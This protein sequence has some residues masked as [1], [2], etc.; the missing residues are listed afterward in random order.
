[1][2]VIEAKLNKPLEADRSTDSHMKAHQAVVEEVQRLQE[3]IDKLQTS[4]S[5]QLGSAAV[6]GT[7]DQLAMQSTLTVLS[8]RMATIQMKASG[9]RQLL[10]ERVSDRL[11][12]QHQEQ[13]LQHYLNQADQMDQWLLSTRE[14]LTSFLL[15]SAEEDTIFELAFLLLLLQ[16]MLHEIEQKVVALSELT[17]R[18][19]SLLLEGRQETRMDMR[20]D[21]EQLARKLRT[22]KGSLL[23]LQRMLQDKHI[24][25][26]VSE[27][28][29]TL[30]QGPSVQD[31]LVQAHT[32]HSQHHQ[33]SLQRQRL[34]EQLAEQKKLLQSVASRGEEILI[35]QASPSS[36]SMTEPFSPEILL[37]REIRAAQYQMRQRWESLRKELSTKL[38]LLQK[39]LEQDHKQQVYSRTAAGTLFKGEMGKTEDK[40]SLKMLYEVFSQTMK[41]MSCQTGASEGKVILME[42]HLYQAVSATSSWLDGVENTLFSGPVLL[43]ENAETQLQNQEALGKDVSEVTGEVSHSR[44][45]LGQ[46][47]GLC[48]E[49][50]VLLEDTLDCLTERLQT[51]DSALE[52]RCEH[53]RTRMQELTAYQVSEAEEGLRKFEQRITQL[54]TR[55]TELQ[56][57]QMSTNEMLKLQD[58]YEELMMTVGS[59]RSGL[60]QNM[61]LK[62]QYE[63]ALQDLADMVGTA[64]DKMAGDQRV[65]ASSVEEVQ[66][67]I[68]KH[69]EFFQGLESHM[70]LTET[71]FRKISG[72]VVPR[73]K[74]A[75]EERLTQAQGVLKQAHRRGVELEYIL[76][77]WSRLVPDYQALCMQLEAVEGSIPTVGLVEETEESL[78]ERSSLYQSLKGRLTEHQHKLSQVLE[79]GKRL[80]L[81]VCC[82][83]L[84]TQLTMLGEH[85]PRC[86]VHWMYQKES[87]ELIGWL[88]SAAVVPQEMEARRDH[89]SA[90]LD[91][92]KEVESHSSLKNSVLTEG[93]QLLRLKRVGTTALR[94]DLAHIDLEWTQLLTLIP[95]VQEK[96]HQLQMEKL[97]S[98]HAISELVNWMSL[99][100]NVIGEDEENLKG[101]VGSTVIQDYLQ[102]YKGFRVDVRCKQLTVDFVN[103]SVL[104]ISDQDVE[105]KRSDQTDFAEKLGVMNR[106]WQLLQGLITE[107]VQFLET[108]LEAWLNYE[109]N[110]QGLKTWL[111]A[112]EERLKR[113]PRIEDLTSVQN[114][115]NDC[116][117]MEEKVKE[118]EG[119][120]ERVEEQACALIQNKTDEACAV[121]METLQAVNHTW[122]NLDHLIGQLKI[123]LV[124]VLDQWNLYKLSSEE[125]NGYLMEGRYSVSRFRLLTG[126]LEAVQLQVESHQSLQEEL[127]K[128]EGSLRKFGSVTHQLLKECHP[129]VSDSLNNTLKD[130]NARWSSLLEEI[131][132]C[133]R[134]SKALL[135]L[136]QH[137]KE[138]YGKSSSSVQLQE[139][140]A[141]RLL[142]TA[143]TK[144]ITDEEVSTW[145]QDCSELLRAQAPVKASLQVIQELG[146][147]LKQQVETSA[148]S[149]VQSDHLSLTQRL[150]TVEQALSRQLT[151]L[152][153]GVQDYETFSEQLGALG[154]WMVEAEEALKVQDPNGSSDLSI[155]QDRMEELKRQILRFSSMAHD[156]EHLNELGYRLPLNDIEIK[157][158]QNLNRSWSAANTQTTER[159]SK[160]QSFLLQQQTFLEK[161]ETWMEFLVQTEEKLAVEI[162]GNY[163][164]LMEQQR[165]HKLFQAEMFSRQQILH[166]IISDGQRMLAQGQVDDRD[167]FNLK[168]SLLSNQWQGVVRRA[169]QRQ[170]II[171][172]LIRQWQRYRDMSEKLRKWLVEVSHPAEALLAGAPVPL[173]QT[174][175]MLD[176]VQIKEKVLQRQQ[177]SYILTV[178]A[179]KQ[180][181]LSAD[182]RAEVSLQGELTDIQDRWRCATICLEEQRRELD[183]LM[184]DWE[185]C[186][187]G[188]EGS[189]EKLREFKRQ[190]SQPLPDHH[191]DLQAEQMRCKDLEKTFDGWTEDLA[192]LTVL[193]E[194]LSS[195]ISAEDL[196]VLQERMELL[197]RQWE[198]ICHQLS[199]RQQQVGEKL[200]EWVVFKEKNRELCD[201]LTQMESKVSQNR[202][203]RIEEMI[204]KLRKDYYEEIAVA[205]EN[206]QQLHQ[207]GER[208]ARASHE[209]KASEIEHKLS[210]VGERWQHLLDLI[211]ARL[212]KLR[213]TLVAVQQLDKNMI[214][215]RSWLTHIETELSR[216]ILYDNCDSQEIQRKLDLQQ[217]NTVS[218]AWWYVYAASPTPIVIVSATVIQLIEETWRLWQKFLEDFM[219]FE[220]WLVTSEKTAALPN[221]SGVLYTVAKEELKKFEAFQR[222][223]HESLTQLETINKQYR[224]LAREN[225]TDSSCR[226]REMS[227]DGNQRWDNLQKRV[228][229]ILRRLKHFISQREEFETA[230]ESVVVWLTEMDL[231][232]TNIEHFSECDIQAKIKQLRA[233]QQ[234]IS[235]TTGK[236]EHIIHQGEVLLEKSEPLDAAVIEEELEE[237][238]RYYQEV[239]GRVE[240]YYKKLIR[241]PVKYD[242]SFSDREIELD[243]PGDLSSIPLSEQLGDCLS[244]PLPSLTAPLRTGAERSGRGSPATVDS[245]P[246]EWD[247]DYDLRKRL[248]SASRDLGLASDHG[249]HGEEGS[250]QGSASASR[251]RPLNRE[252]YAFKP[253]SNRIP[254]FQSSGEGGTLDTHILQLDR[255][256]DTS[257]LHL[258]QTE[259]IIRSRTPTG[260][261]LDASYMGYMRLLGECRSSIDTVKR[262]GYEL[263][264]EGDKALGLADPN[265]DESQTTGVIQRWE[266]L[267]AQAL[268]KEIRLKQNLQQ[269]QQFNS[270]LNAVWV[271]LEQA[272]EELEQ[273]RRLD[274]S[275]DIQTIE[276]RIKKLKELQKAVDKRKATVLSINLCSAEFVQST[277]EESQ[278]LQA[279]LK[280]MNNRWDRLGTSLGEWR[281]ALQKALMQC[282]DFHEMSHGLLLWLENID[283]RR[284]EI[285]PI[286]PIQ[287]RNTLHEHHKT[288]LKIRCELLDTQRKVLSLQDMSLQL[289]VNSE[290]SDCLE[291]KE[292]VHVIGNRLK[293]LFKEV[294]RDLRE[295]E[296]ILDITSSQQDLSTW[297]SADELDTTSGSISPVSGRSTPSRRRSVTYSNPPDMVTWCPTRRKGKSSSSSSSHFLYR[298]LWVA[299][300]FQLLFL[301]LL[302]GMVCLPMCEGDFDCSQSNNFARSFHPMLQY[303]NGPPPV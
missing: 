278:D 240:N 206:K 56:A 68:D 20:E 277:T 239:F 99:M 123:S 208:L 223:V 302:V 232:L 81:S 293:L 274:L 116:Q 185:T 153:T 250:Y 179:G 189:L 228:A 288:L 217:V 161:C 167:E 129:S 280:E 88:Q 303:T 298:V 18:S 94:S 225:R 118:K 124:S 24:N 249:E 91:F 221:S 268:S 227:H 133:L 257:R 139:E 45:L 105:S 241:L 265:D 200:N 145:I 14:A 243:E 291:A 165:A 34:K 178:E 245:I 176:A 9:E 169:Q 126:S 236:V 247:H 1:M 230:R 174:R 44:G 201:W 75:L 15:P 55:G 199:L 122:A 112:Q 25:I 13:T 108:L 147:Q 130:V 95:G 107:R 289:L 67:L 36:V 300:P 180:L 220:E 258:Q 98:R 100:E 127:E 209:T 132:E 248:E 80:Q 66:I 194:S 158:M 224:R 270:D 244:S 72:L 279:R 12:E 204:E 292:K 286:D 155:I 42:Q 166:S 144:D 296:K 150:A 146:D 69:K 28:D 235:L 10:E 272:G 212:K 251:L 294:T 119:E 30:S 290:G 282:H 273:Q 35:K 193:R 152:Q 48:A 229:S 226:L 162:S 31:C 177:G 115:L 211:G 267:Q 8:Q 233:F 114:A 117:E 297:S 47:T 260:P 171:D 79:E 76:E 202:D 196:S 168:L 2:E 255:V 83:G 62:G 41:E 215:L 276:L 96:L 143:C 125:M 264:G 74:Q 103:Q 46:P 261:E 262:V 252:V 242:V 113:K 175:S 61:A 86:T 283:R 259:N 197:Q 154:R 210:M 29:S 120:V 299:V 216:P 222:Q 17:M 16:N 27:S 256:L 142:E 32:T 57:E 284:N 214:S 181:L 64:Q 149:A 148:A 205:Q 33:D 207:L 164:S 102:K 109:N 275:T 173:Q 218:I 157:C 186:E 141:D 188:I 246:L 3:E 192:H 238:R 172:S 234:E 213:E 195:Y 271:W 121:V 21:T 38:Q 58:A 5:D 40:S 19:E 85:W 52:R 151:T 138:L 281:A 184:K 7:A 231:Q 70:I 140:Q 87:S 253:L 137:Y 128:Q 111:L 287:D 160:L 237:L 254:I 106:R 203:V 53:M 26:Q 92:C 285:V 182:S 54:K 159:F 51:L 263:K 134:S 266:L 73:E 110:I 63:R 131:S 135:Q 43:T 163:Q 191:E 65:I 22:L 89:L 93:N 84:D 4:F 50:Q 219:H 23:E 59:R 190:F 11:E 82:P 269:W 77:T 39:T 156:L 301:L 49:D 6:D 60:N 183:N 104:Q 101:A 136:W 187:R 198:E 90:F 37:E 97:A 71:F 78:T 295:L 170:G